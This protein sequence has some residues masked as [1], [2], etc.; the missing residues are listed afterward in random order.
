LKSKAYTD[1]L[2]TSLSMDETV[3]QLK[4]PITF[5]GKLILRK[6]L[7]TK[8]R[9]AVAQR[10]FGKVSQYKECLIG[11]AETATY[12]KAFTVYICSLLKRLLTVL[13][14]SLTELQ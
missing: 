7:V 5:F 6:W 11:K 8:A 4:S 10:E 9:N 3:A 1:T 14:T 13:Y 12:S 2:T